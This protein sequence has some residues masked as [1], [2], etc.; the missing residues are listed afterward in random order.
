MIKTSGP[1]RGSPARYIAAML[2]LMAAMV[3]I[4]AGFLQMIRALERG[5]YGTSSNTLSFITLGFGGAFLGI[6]IALL[7]WELSVRHN[8]RH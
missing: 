6:G 1:Q 7:I 5:G 4:P 2:S 8:I 3:T